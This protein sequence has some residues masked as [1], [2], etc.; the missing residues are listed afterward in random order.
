M[1]I[2]MKVSTRYFVII[3]LLSVIFKVNSQNCNT[4]NVN[5]G[6]DKYLICGDSVPLFGST[7]YAYPDSVLWQWTPNQSI[8]NSQIRNP[9]VFPS[10]TSS[11]ILTALTP[12]GCV[13]RDTIQVIVSMPKIETGMDRILSCGNTMPIFPNTK[14]QTLNQIGTADLKG[15]SFVSSDSGFV[16]GLG[17]KVYKTTDGGSSWMDVSTPGT[18][19]LLGAHFLSSNSGMV[20][21]NNGIIY[22]TIN[23]GTTWQIVSTGISQPI[24]DMFFVN[25]QLGF[26]AGGT[27]STTTYIFKTSNGGSS[28]G[29]IALPNSNR[30]NGLHFVS[31]DTGY[32]V[33]DQGIIM[34]TT[35]SGV[36]WQNNQLSLNNALY[37]VYFI[38]SQIG[39]ACG[40]FGLMLK[41]TNA[42]QTW[43]KV[44]TNT[45]EHLYKMCFINTSS[46]YVVGSNGSIFYTYNEGYSWYPVPALI[47]SN[48][49]AISSC[50]DNKIFAVGS[51][52]TVLKNMNIFSEY[53]WTPSL[54]VGNAVVENTSFSPSSSQ[55]YHLTATTQNA[56]QTADSVF[57]QVLPAS[58]YANVDRT[59]VCADEFKLYGDFEWKPVVSN[60]TKLLEQAVVDGNVV[61]IIYGDSIMKIFNNG[62]TIERYK[63]GSGSG[64]L[65]KTLAHNQNGVYVAGGYSGV[66]AIS[67]NGG[68]QWQYVFTGNTQNIN[69]I[70][71]RN[72]TFGLA[73]CDNG[74]VL[75]TLDGGTSW[76]AI[77]TGYIK[78]LNAVS[79]SPDGTIYVVGQ[80]GIILK[81][82]NDA[83]SFGA[84]GTVTSQHLNDIKML[85]NLNGFMCGNG[86]AFYKTVDGGI[87]WEA[88]S[89]GSLENYT[90][91]FFLNNYIA[92]LTGAN[93]LIFKS[94]DGGENW[95]SM[96]SNTQQELRSV[97]FTDYRHGIA[98]GLN[99]TLLRY[100][101]PYSNNSWTDS[102]GLQHF[103]ADVV[104]PFP[105]QT[106]TYYFS[107]ETQSGCSD[108][109]TV[110]ITVSPLIVSTGGDVTPTCGTPIELN[111]ETNLINNEN[112]SYQWIPDTFLSNADTSNP[113]CTP[114][115]NI[116]YVVKVSNPNGCEAYDT[117]WVFV[118]STMVTASNDTTIFCGQQTQISATV[119]NIQSGT[120]FLW[121]PAS[122]LNNSEIMSP[123][124]SPSDTTTYV[125]IVTDPNGCTGTDSVI[126]AV[127][128]LQISLPPNTQLSCGE[129][130]Q[131]SPTINNP[132]IGLLNWEW[133]P[134]TGLNNPFISDPIV[135]YGGEI[136]YTVLVSNQS[137]QCS[138]SATVHLIPQPALIDAEICMTSYILGYDRNIVQWIVP[139]SHVLDSINV[140]KKNQFGD[141][142]KQTTIKAQSGN[143]WTD[144]HAVAQ[145]GSAEYQISILD[146]CGFT[147]PLS[148][149]HETIF[150]SLSLTE[151]NKWQISWT[152]YIGYAPTAYTIYRSYENKPFEH[153]ATVANSSYSFVD[154][155]Q[156][157][158]FTSYYVGAVK[159]DTCFTMVNT[160]RT[161]S[162]SNIASN[163]PV[164]VS[165][166][167]KIYP[168]PAIDKII[169]TG[170]DLVGA[171]IEIFDAKGQIVYTG[172]SM[173][174]AITIPISHLRKGIFF[175]RIV[176][177][178]KV[179]NEK[180][181]KI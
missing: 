66:L 134:Q 125:V 111:A 79:F 40:E 126:V 88:I 67:K 95:Y 41:T 106:T 140:F 115:T 176:N 30:I 76:T 155:E 57:I 23:G 45:S 123:T 82:S 159:A 172:V 34:K 86:G 98:I 27:G 94:I 150:A 181:I 50:Y 149:P 46:A 62:E 113:I 93:G 102:Q 143:V 47:L 3:A 6:V 108:V 146:T 162:F 77:N 124:A 52:G 177:E 55:M 169:L 22:R 21:G 24:R 100:D 10:S 56:C 18:Y 163:R 97:V 38:N 75:K 44:N 81:S 89:T 165:T 71:F 43:V 117:M 53:Q 104:D 154:I 87:S 152:P 59:I 7:N 128:P 14:W 173:E 4:L 151:Q 139:P 110:V 85:S 78:N 122:S 145:Y 103:N 63:I 171:D 9:K 15:V 101:Y 180:F 170:S 2:F 36:L 91:I 142:V 1:T 32:A 74:Y 19:D 26:A 114:L 20:Y 109:D 84:L 141:I 64:S 72:T 58:V 73:V 39:F 156:K 131:L 179:I 119:S 138:A 49:W 147:T 35:N 135:S 121:Q 48:L 129:Q 25:S 112:V 127:I 90:S 107:M 168:R 175:I 61:Q 161:E 17:G 144:P 16:C 148:S 130:I 12:S 133:T 28:W 70:K 164:F 136:T 31:Q 65:F 166:D 92:H 80:D 42:G 178:V 54:G 167:F 60:T 120:E 118:G 153:I 8:N 174:S 160:Y 69:D 68:Y 157:E 96:K 132:S 137:A 29:S 51:N 33:C 13:M 105:A 83:A 37:D 158:G 5:L 116:Q 11:Y 99:G